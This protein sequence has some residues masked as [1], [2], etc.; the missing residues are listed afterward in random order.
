TRSPAWSALLPSQISF[1]TRFHPPRPISSQTKFVNKQQSTQIS[2]PT[3]KELEETLR[4]ATRALLDHGT[5]VTDILN[6]IR[7]EALERRDD[8]DLVQVIRDIGEHFTYEKSGKGDAVI[9]NIFKEYYV[10]EVL[11]TDDETLAYLLNSTPPLD[12]RYKRIRYD[13]GRKFVDAKEDKE[14]PHVMLDI[15]AELRNAKEK[16]RKEPVNDYRYS[17]DELDSIALYEKMRPSVCDIFYVRDYPREYYNRFIFRQAWKLGR[18]REA[19]PRIHELVPYLKEGGKWPDRV[20]DLEH[21]NCVERAKVEIGL[22][23]RDV[24]K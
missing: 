17:M 7:S 18:I 8:E 12:P 14:F 23:A 13:R 11:Q 10:A 4:T 20:E 6:I 22:R 5:P 1:S 15:V 9:S 2:Q 21:P 19:F 16:K 24:W 3:R